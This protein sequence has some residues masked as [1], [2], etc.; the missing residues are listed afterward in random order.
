MYADDLNKILLLPSNVEQAIEDWLEE[1][2]ITFERKGC[3]QYKITNGAVKNIMFYPS[4]HKI[5]VQEEGKNYIQ[6]ANSNALLG[7]IKGTLAFK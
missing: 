2:E 1:N 5:M 3:M 4:T 6:T 7:V